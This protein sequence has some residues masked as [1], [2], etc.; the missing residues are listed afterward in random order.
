VKGEVYYLLVLRTDEKQYFERAREVGS[1]QWLMTRWQCCSM[2][3]IVWRNYKRDVHLL[4]FT[5]LTFVYCMIWGDELAVV[6]GVSHPI[7][8]LSA[9]DVRDG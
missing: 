5:Q 8:T 6:V 3:Y 9:A 1:K 4:R 2:A 7:G